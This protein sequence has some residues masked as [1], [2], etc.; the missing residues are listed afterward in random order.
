MS[1]TGQGSV[2]EY[3]GRRA[4]QDGWERF[5]SLNFGEEEADTNF[6]GS[7]RFLGQDRTANLLLPPTPDTPSVHT[8]T[9]GSL[10][11][12]HE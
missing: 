3:R 2:P 7:A 8:A 11:C 5:L 1:R 9:G 12:T 6:K 10:L 4:W